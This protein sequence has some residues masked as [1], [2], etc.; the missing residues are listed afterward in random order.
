MEGIRAGRDTPLALCTP[1]HATFAVWVSA[2]VGSF[3][4]HR[5]T[6]CPS[7]HACHVSDFSYSSHVYRKSL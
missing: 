6:T 5:V 3:N 4:H 7:L 2:V 1:L